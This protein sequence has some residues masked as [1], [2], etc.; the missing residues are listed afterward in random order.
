MSE[1]TPPDDR[2]QGDR[3]ETTGADVRLQK[4]PP[5][6][7]PGTTP[8][9]PEASQPPPP[10]PWA[11]PYSAPM[12]GQPYGAT[13][14]TMSPQDE[15]TWAMLSHGIVLGVTVVSGGF[16]GFIA[17]IVMYIAFKDRGPF[18]RAHAANA[19]NIQ[20]IAG[21]VF[22]VSLPL[23]FVLIG[24]VT[25]AIAWVA[26]VVAHIIGM[27]RANNGEWFDP[28]FTPKFVR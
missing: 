18:V 5:A 23:M 17:A 8:H 3:A 26:A 11:P 15:K 12:T 25:F 16:L 2:P 14:T 1:T 28:P 7:I 22:L 13:P 27:V 10:P 6:A 19:L 24:F 4:S 20:I 21:I 9:P